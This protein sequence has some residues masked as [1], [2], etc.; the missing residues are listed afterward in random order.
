MPKED[1]T[2]VGTSITAQIIW[3]EKVREYKEHIDTK[4]FLTISEDQH[5][6]LTGVI[7]TEKFDAVVDYFSS[8]IH[9][10]MF[11]F[12]VKDLITYSIREMTS[13]ELDYAIQPLTISV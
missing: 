7:S 12:D 5:I 2:M 10:C 13:E 9:N 6:I 3:I 8:D 11:R 1:T 4:F